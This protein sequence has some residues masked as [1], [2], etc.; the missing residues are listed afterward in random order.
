MSQRIL[1]IEGDPV[2]RES[3]LRLLSDHGHEVE[4]AANGAQAVKRLPRGRFDTVI[5]DLN[6]TDLGGSL[7]TRL[8]QADGAHGPAPLLIGL[9]E[10][11]YLLA[12]SRV[13]GG[14]F[15]AILSKP[16]RSE[17]LLDAIAAASDQFVTKGVALPLQREVRNPVETQHAARNLSM[18]HWRR[19]GLQTPPKVFACPTPTLDQEKALNLCFDV[20]APQAADL[21]LLLERHGMSEAKRMAHSPDT[22]HRPIIALSPDH[23]DLCDAVFEITSDISWREI[24]SLLDRCLTPPGMVPQVDAAW[25]ASF[26]DDRVISLTH[27]IVD[28]NIAPPQKPTFDTVAKGLRASSQKPGRTSSLASV[29]GGA[30][31]SG[32]YWTRPVRTEVNV[33]QEASVQG[34]KK[35][36]RARSAAQVLLIEGNEMGSPGLTLALARAGH[37]VCRVQDPQASMLAATGTLFDV[38]VID[39]NVSSEPHIDLP[40]LVRC[41]RDL[42]RNLPIILVGAEPSGKE[43]HDLARVGGISLLAKASAQVNLVEA[44]SAAISDGGA[45]SCLSNLR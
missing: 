14:V 37:I 44:V 33:D 20:V 8:S 4:L 22:V 31:G 35:G 24:A 11:R 16:L 26:D 12:V 28:D 13:S 39:M 23:A 42:Q 43:R 34:W 7:L 18:A 19:C 30:D 27:K 15:K 40:E 32:D 3:L 17:A 36:V 38:G 25:P 5:L 1:V 41:L 6:L 45:H 2:L 9:V 10:H 21:I 29:G